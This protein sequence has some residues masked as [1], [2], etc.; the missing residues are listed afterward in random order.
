MMSRPVQYVWSPCPA[1]LHC[2]HFMSPFVSMR[3][4]LKVMVGVSIWPAWRLVVWMASR[5]WARSSSWKRLRNAGI[6]AWS[7]DVPSAVKRLSLLSKIVPA[8]SI[9]SMI[10]G[11]ICV[12]WFWLI[13]GAFDFTSG[14]EVEADSVFV[15]FKARAKLNMTV[16]ENVGR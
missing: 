1:A 14:A 8:S 13:I 2:I 10:S 4:A 15:F 6:S 16:F 11:L 3:R 5:M 9:T 12:K 7:F